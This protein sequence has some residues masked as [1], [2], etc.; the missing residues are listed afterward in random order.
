MGKGDLYQLDVDLDDK[1]EPMMV[2]LINI[3]DNSFVISSYAWFTRLTSTM[4]HFLE[5]NY[6]MIQKD[7]KPLNLEGKI[8]KLEINHGA[9]AKKLYFPMEDI[10]N[11][12]FSITGIPS[13][14]KSQRPKPSMCCSGKKK[15]KFIPT[16]RTVKMA[17]ALLDW[18]KKHQDMTEHEYAKLTK[19]R[20]TMKNISLVDEDLSPLS[21]WKREKHT[22]LQQGIFFDKSTISLTNIDQ[23]NKLIQEENNST[24][25]SKMSQEK[26]MSKRMTYKKVSVLK[27][28]EL[29]GGDKKTVIEVSDGEFLYLIDLYGN[30]KQVS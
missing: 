22:S 6:G 21:A 19:V 2:P 11:H 25:N 5:M 10:G 18:M 4:M 17:N 15:Q 3:G 29:E 26:K 13:I 23:N 24:K 7:L 27:H 16:T 14:P 12:T 8:R 9:N 30:I 1:I 28:T 20:A